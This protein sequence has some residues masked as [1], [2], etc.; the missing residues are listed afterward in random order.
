MKKRKFV[1]KNIYDN[2]LGNTP[3]RYQDWQTTVTLLVTPRDATSSYQPVAPLLVVED[4][5]VT[6]LGTD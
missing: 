1:L 6:I 4:I 5:L 2:A 3:G